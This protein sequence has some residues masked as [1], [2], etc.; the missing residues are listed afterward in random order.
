MAADWEEFQAQYQHLQWLW[1]EALF[2]GRPHWKQ[3]QR[4]HEEL[5]GW[6]ALLAGLELEDLG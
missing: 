5:C 2:S 3:L 4:W 6:E 1:G